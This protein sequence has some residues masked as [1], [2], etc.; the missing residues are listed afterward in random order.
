MALSCRKLSQL[1]ARLVDW[2]YPAIP[3]VS[4]CLRFSFRS[5]AAG[6]APAPHGLRLLRCHGGSSIDFLQDCVSS[7]AE[8][9]FAYRFAELQ[10]IDPLT[11]FPQQPGSIRAGDDCIEVEPAVDYFRERSDRNLAP[12]SHPVQQRALTRGG[13]AGRV[14]LQESDMLTDRRVILPNL[15]R[16]S[17]LAGGRTH[18]LR[19]Q[20]LPYTFP[21][22]Q[23][24]QS[25]GS[26]D[27]SGVLTSCQF[28]QSGVHI[29]A[30]GVDAEIG[31]HCLQ[32]RLPPQAAGP[33]R[34]R[35]SEAP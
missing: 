25:G 18:Q 29:S 5:K 17:A 26:E 30:Q 23:P 11:R 14:V 33:D 15:N 31:P 1:S 22:A 28:A 21:F 4:A 13:G 27:D 2:A 34:W 12:S 9:G 7:T 3:S 10:R 8:Q 19:R 6:G 20:H 35:R 16:Q 24:I 32:L